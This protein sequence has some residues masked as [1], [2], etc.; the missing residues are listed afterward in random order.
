MKII[1]I[2]SMAESLAVSIHSNYPSSS[3]VAVLK[4]G[5][6]SIINLIITIFIVLMI[7]SLTNHFIP[8]LIAVVGFPILRY[9]SGGIHLR[10]A[11][12]CNVVTSSFMLISVY[13]PVQYWYN[14]FILHMV[15]I[16]LL[17]LYAPSGIKRSKLDPEHYP[18]LK[19]IAVMIVLTN[20][21]F[22]TSVLTVAFFIQAVLTT[23]A[24]Q[25]MIRK[26]NV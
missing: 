25:R 17:L 21:A 4:F 22:Q 24:V 15:T 20:L 5:L 23:P 16:I 10:S 3:P 19:M 1:K 14:G 12:M 13:I 8:A 7:G 9:F 26:M 11:N 18:K 6:I 2:E